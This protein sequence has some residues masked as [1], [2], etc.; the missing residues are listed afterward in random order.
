MATPFAVT[1]FFWLTVLDNSGRLAP[2]PQ[3]ELP[4]PV[5]TPLMWSEESCLL[6][7]GKMAHPERYVCQKWTGEAT[8]RFSFGSIGEAPQPAAKEPDP[9]KAD[10]TKAVEPPKRSEIPVRLTTYRSGQE[11]RVGMSPQECTAYRVAGEP[12]PSAPAKFEPQ[13]QKRVVRQQQSFDPLSAFVSLF[14]PNNNW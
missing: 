7:R 4:A 6:V 2:V 3:S 12:P 9:P 11:C 8:S 1:T 5:S 13:K 10:P 14:A